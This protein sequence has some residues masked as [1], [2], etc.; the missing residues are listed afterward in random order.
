MRPKNIRG[1][2][3]QL[4]QRAIAEAHSE[5]ART[6]KRV[7]IGDWLEDALR[8]KLWLQDNQS[9]LLGEIRQSIKN[10]LKKT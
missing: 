1:I 8:V 3:D 4:Y 9:H 6:G 2:D 7:N 5:T 10:Q